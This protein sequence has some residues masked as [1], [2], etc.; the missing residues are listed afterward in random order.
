M[1]LV[2]NPLQQELS[3]LTVPPELRQGAPRLRLEGGGRG[4]RGGG[5]EAGLD[6]LQVAGVAEQVAVQGV[7]PVTL[8]VIQLQLTILTVITLHVIVLV[9]G[10]HSDSFVRAL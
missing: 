5:G 4:G 2:I 3:L 7:A 9:H 1:S 8:F 6:V 10:H